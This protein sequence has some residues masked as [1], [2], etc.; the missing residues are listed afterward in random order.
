MVINTLVFDKVFGGNYSMI[1]NDNRER[2]RE[3]VDF[4]ML[5]K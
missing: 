4:V 5:K 1:Y 3:R 2:E